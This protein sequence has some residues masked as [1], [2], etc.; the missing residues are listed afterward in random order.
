MKLL[1]VYSLLLSSL[2]VYAHQSDVSTT[3]LAEQE[4]G[5]WLV[6]ISASLTAFQHEI[7]M[8]Y[9]DY[10]SPEE[11]QEFVIGHVKKHLKIR[12]DDYKPLDFGNAYV[13]LGHETKVILPLSDVPSTFRTLSVQNSSFEDIHRNQSALVI[14][15]K[16]LASKHVVLNK[17]NAHTAHL[18]VEGT[19][20]TPIQASGSKSVPIP[21]Y[22]TIGILVI[23]AGVF[24]YVGMPK[25]GQHTIA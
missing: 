13:Q 10:T 4:N 20:F 8:H 19:A 15:K 2:G 1:I 22:L 11:F 21:V 25:S 9:P 16:G 24:V 23:A 3:M 18:Q 7:Q 5:T 12:F 6:Q 17:E 14:V